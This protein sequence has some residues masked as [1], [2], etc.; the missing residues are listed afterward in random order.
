MLENN[1]KMRCFE[2]FFSF[3]EDIFDKFGE[4][5]YFKYIFTY[6]F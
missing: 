3:I 1:L 2:K 5:V 4:Y 6:K